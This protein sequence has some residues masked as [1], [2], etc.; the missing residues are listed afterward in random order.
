MLHH[1]STY[2]PVYMCLY[3]LQVVNALGKGL[4]GLLGINSGKSHQQKR[5]EEQQRQEEAER[6]AAAARET[7]AARAAGA[8]YGSRVNV[9]G[10]PV[11]ADNERDA[12]PSAPAMVRE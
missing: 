11:D 6:A 1:A 8:G 2:Q 5:Q 10:R 3:V 4:M 7:A 9:H 12:L